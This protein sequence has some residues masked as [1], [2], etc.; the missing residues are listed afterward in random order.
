MDEQNLK[1]QVR[2]LSSKWPNSAFAIFDFDSAEIKLQRQK[3]P[4]LDSQNQIV[5]KME[6][7]LAPAQSFYLKVTFLIINK[8][9][10][11]NVEKTNIV[12]FFE[13]QK[14][15]NFSFDF[16]A[17]EIDEDHGWLINGEFNIDASF[18]L[19]DSKHSDDDSNSDSD[20]N[21]SSSSDGDDSESFETHWL[22]ENYTKKVGLFKSNTYDIGPNKIHFETIRCEPDQADKTQFTID[23]V[24]DEISVKDKIKVSVTLMNQNQNNLKFEKIAEVAQKGDKITAS[25]HNFM[26]SQLTQQKG[27]IKDGQLMVIVRLS[28]ADENNNNRIKLT[29][30]NNR[31]SN[32]ISYG[33]NNNYNYNYNINS[34]K[35]MSKENT[36]YVGLLNQGATCYMNSMLQ[37]LYHTPAFRKLIYQ[38]PTKVDENEKTNIILN[39]QRLF[40]QMQFSDKACSTKS[41]TQSFGW[42][43]RRTATQHDTQEFARVLIDNI[44]EKIKNDDNL[45][46]GINN[47]LQIQVQK[48]IRC[49]N[50]NFQ[51]LTTENLLDLMM[52]VK[53]CPTLEDS[54]KKYLEKD[55]LVGDNQYDTD[56]PEFKKQ[57]AEMGSE[58][59]SFP[60]VLHLHLGRF[61]YDYDYF[62]NIK[63]NDR[64]EFPKVIDLD[65]YLAKD[66]DRSKPNIYDLHGVLVHSGNV[67]FGHYFAY[68]RTSTDP[69]WYKFDDSHVTK[70]TEEQAIDNN[71]GGQKSRSFSA[72]FLV[73][74]RRCDAPK[75]FE[76]ISDDL[77]P[78]HVRDYIEHPQATT[79]LSSN[80][81]T[82]SSTENSKLESK[83]VSSQ[84]QLTNKSVAVESKAE[85]N[86]KKKEIDI[87]EIDVNG[88]KLKTLPHFQ[89]ENEANDENKDDTDEP[90]TQ[91]E[92][93]PLVLFDYYNQNDPV[94]VL[95]ANS[96]AT[97]QELIKFISKSLNLNYNPDNDTILFYNKDFTADYSQQNSIILQL[98]ST[99]KSMISKSY[100]DN[101]SYLF[102]RYLPGTKEED[103]SQKLLLGAKL[104]IDGYSYVKRVDVIVPKTAK[105]FEIVDAILEKIDLNEFNIDKDSL[106]DNGNTGK[107]KNIRL[108]SLRGSKIVKIMSLS[109][110]AGA[111]YKEYRLDIIPENQRN[112]SD[113]EM[114]I[115]LSTS[116]VKS[117]HT[118]LVYG[119]PFF[120]K[121]KKDSTVEQLKLILKD[122]LQIDEKEFPRLKLFTGGDYITLSPK[123][124]ITNDKVLGKLD[125]KNGIYIVKNMNCIANSKTRRTEEALKIYN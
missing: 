6:T 5:F 117:N 50:V 13:K 15:V 97:P 42:N 52:T 10:T 46:D 54:F 74:V 69:Q 100:N 60:P 75:I 24:I 16:P 116:L 51:R 61:E 35:D 125:L 17:D 64:F 109:A 87:D 36:G 93:M 83:Q 90:A 79:T 84:N 123:N 55:E 25:F 23:V 9:P 120:M 32:N 91:S 53:G 19:D 118:P 43:S 49:K 121:L 77:V 68:L 98:S 92:L 76:P 96:K 48:Y 18:C 31:Y 21:E 20:S 67:S 12:K 65:P 99:V 111:Y 26:Q 73:Y 114:V 1:T 8:D 108:M 45:K 71:Y 58:F 3:Y 85:T 82:K 70:V 72:Y 88:I 122:K 14:I 22:V 102:Y 38:I 30:Y 59:L 37:S 124:E 11:K 94:A 2:R 95:K 101:L 78:Q 106:L 33:I 113:D 81:G 56:D 89:M 105:G 47:L 115:L 39:L 41:L 27:F 34:Y 62:R 119:I 66:A 63:I 7:S 112:L 80:I 86:E 57:D 104:S 29:N 44:K 28:D 40:G 4:Y 107:Y 103:I 110:T